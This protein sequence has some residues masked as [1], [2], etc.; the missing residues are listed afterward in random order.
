M[1]LKGKWVEVDREKLAE[2]LDH[3][4]KV[5]RETRKSG[6]TFYEGMRLLVGDPERDATP[7]SRPRGSPSGPE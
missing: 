2:A 6:L 3:W 1:S 4:K 7:P 5:E